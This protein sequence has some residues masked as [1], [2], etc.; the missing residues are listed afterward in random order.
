MLSARE[1]LRRPAPEKLEIEE[2][3]GRPAV[4]GSLLYRPHVR[5]RHGVAFIVVRSWL[6]TARAQDLWQLKLIKAELPPEMIAAIAGDI[7]AAVTSLTG[8]L[9]RAV[10]PVT[11]GHSNRPDCFSFRLG[12]A[13]AGLLGIEF[14]PC[15]KPRLVKG[16]SHPQENAKLPPLEFMTSP[17]A[18]P[19]L[20]LDDVTTSGFHMEEALIALRGRGTPALGVA[21]V[22]GTI[23]S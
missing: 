16:S 4:F 22:G 2:D 11:C 17:P 23:R 5:S 7:A 1:L 15:F 13:V 21:W 12:L 19:S 18:A 6:A 3:S 10:V 9:F 8:S 14:S 20:L